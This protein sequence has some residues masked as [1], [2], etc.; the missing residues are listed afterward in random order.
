LP[1]FIEPAANGFMVFGFKNRYYGLHFD[2]GVFRPDRVDYRYRLEGDS[3]EEVLRQIP[4]AVRRIE[5]DAKSC[6][7]RGE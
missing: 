1:R 5:G 6:A 4:E 3:A 2:E 7:A